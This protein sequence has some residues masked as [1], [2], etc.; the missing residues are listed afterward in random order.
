MKV[1][2]NKSYVV[3]IA[4]RDF[5]ELNEFINCCVRFIDNQGSA[6]KPAVT[7]AAYTAAKEWQQKVSRFT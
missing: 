5:D 2:Q 3:E 1:R 4:E 6:A 7:D